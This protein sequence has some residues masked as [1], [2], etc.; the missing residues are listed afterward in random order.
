MARDDLPETLEALERKLRDLERELGAP[1]PATPASAPAVST[2]GGLDDLARQVDDLG[3][4]RAQLERVGRE[5]EE[6]YARVLARL[7]ADA[8]ASPPPPPPP[9]APAPLEPG[10]EHE[11][12]AAPAIPPGS[13]TVDAGPFADLAALGAFEAA[14]GA[15]AGVDAVEVTGFEGRR[16]VL[17]VHLG[18]PVALETELRRSLPTRIVRAV[19]APGRL[20][21]DLEAHP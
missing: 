15:I 14:L 21:V 12:E 17:S 10:P 13:I 1:A 6:E 4:F 8:S 20:S 11:H 19:S 3:R 18:A 5:L 9:S 16:A 7:Q 2:G